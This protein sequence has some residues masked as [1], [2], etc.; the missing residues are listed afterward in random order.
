[1]LSCSLSA[2]DS[3]YRVSLLGVLASPIIWPFAF[4]PSSSTAF[5]STVGSLCLCLGLKIQELKECCVAREKYRA[6]KSNADTEAQRLSGIHR[7]YGTPTVNYLLNKPSVSNI[8]I[9][10]RNSQQSGA[11]KSGLLAHTVFLWKDVSAR[12]LHDFFLM[13]ASSVSVI[14]SY[15]LFRR[16]LS[17][18]S[19]QG[20]LPNHTSTLVS[21]KYCE[22]DRKRDGRFKNLL[23]I[24]LFSL[25]H[26]RKNLKSSLL[27]TEVHVSLFADLLSFRLKDPSSV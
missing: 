6:N 25:L 26:S 1:M 4:H 22:G 12:L 21:I 2:V 11:R 24:G 27:G 7:F 14:S 19:A 16:L 13:T 5:L 17:K 10:H 3:L 23:S 15:F 9:S 20:I 8:F 18:Q